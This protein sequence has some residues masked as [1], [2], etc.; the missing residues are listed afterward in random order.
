MMTRKADQDRD[1]SILHIL[2]PFWVS[3]K[4]SRARDI[5]RCFDGVMAVRY[6]C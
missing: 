6:H 1:L 4:D 2:R 3:L 5:D